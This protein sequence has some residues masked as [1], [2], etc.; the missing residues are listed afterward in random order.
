MAGSMSTR[1]SSIF[2][3]QNVAKRMAHFMT[4]MLLYLPTR[5]L[6]ISFSV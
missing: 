3:H 4:N 2:K 5:I 1:K 6:T